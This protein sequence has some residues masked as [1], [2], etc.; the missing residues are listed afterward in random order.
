ML[1]AMDTLS[2]DG[3]ASAIERARYSGLRKEPWEDLRDTERDTRVEVMR[4]ALEESGVTAAVAVVVARGAQ[5]DGLAEQVAARDAELRARQ[6]E[7]DAD[8]VRLT[9]RISELE[10]ELA[11]ARAAHAA[12]LA[13]TSAEYESELAEARSGE[14]RAVHRAQQAERAL[15]AVRNALAG[16]AVAEPLP[17]AH[18]AVADDE[19]TVAGAVPAAVSAGTAAESAA[20]RGLFGRRARWAH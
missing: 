5:A 7:H 15:D 16:V 12:E 11:D 10:D 17:V 6:A 4:A 13:A 18:E 14:Q 20:Q 2:P 1:G 3:M 8:L 19:G 9:G